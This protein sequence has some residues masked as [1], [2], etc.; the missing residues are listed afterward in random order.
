M[1]LSFSKEAFTRGL[2]NTKLFLV[3]KSPE[4][5]LITGIAAGFVGAY[6]AAKVTEQA[7]VEVEDTKDEM[8]DVM[9]NEITDEYTERDQQQELG[10][11][12]IKG[13][14]RIAKLYAPAIGF[15]VL[16]VTALLASHGVMTRRLTSLS[17]AYS[18]AMETLQAYRAR[19]SDEFGEEAEMLVRKGLHVETVNDAE[20]GEPTNILVQDDAPTLYGRIFDQDTSR[21]FRESYELNLFFLQTQE[22]FANEMLRLRGYVFL[23]EIYDALGFPRTPAG[24]VVGWL[25]KYNPELNND[26]HISFDILSVYNESNGRELRQSNPAF[27][28][29]FNVD[30]EIWRLIGDK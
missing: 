5:L 10:M 18:L 14:L 19:V 30:G 24:Q 20:T 3:H 4:I 9:A 21:E 29:D 2:G 16:S 8:N 27:L 25:Y 22:R 6:F 11:V 17:T 15:G 28:L 26:T 1:K 13:G 12:V 23:N 7:R